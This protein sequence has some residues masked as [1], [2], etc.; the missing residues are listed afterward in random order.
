MTEVMTL[1]S[2]K[3][4]IKHYNDNVSFKTSKDK[5][6]L[7][8]KGQKSSKETLKKCFFLLKYQIL[9]TFLVKIFK[10]ISFIF[11]SVV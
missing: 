6:F 2:R 7:K 3:I 1:L 9:L 10:L 5:K 11:F 8:K 4:I